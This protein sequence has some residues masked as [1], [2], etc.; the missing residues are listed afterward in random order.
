MNKLDITKIALKN[1]KGFSHFNLEFG[2]IKAIILGG[3]NGFGKT[4]LFDAIELVFTGKIDR[5]VNYADNCHDNR[6]A[7]N[8]NELPLVFDKNQNEVLIELYLSSDD[9]NFILCRRAEVS[10]LTNPISFDPFNELLIKIEGDMEYHPITDDELNR[11]ELKDLFANYKFIN[12]LEQEEATSFLKKKEIE[13]SENINHLFNTITFDNKIENVKKV[14]KLFRDKQALLEQELKHKEKEYE[15]LK[16]THF[17]CQETETVD[18]SPLMNG[19]S[20]P[21]DKE[22]PNLTSEKFNELL[23]EGGIL[24]QIDFFIEHKEEY[25]Q[26][27]TNKQIEGILEPNALNNLSFF[28][29]YADLNSEI[30]LYGQYVNGFKKRF[31]LLDFDTLKDFDLILPGKL[32]LIISDE[33]KQK[34][35]KKI[36]TVTELYESAEKLDKTFNKLFTKRNELAD[37]LQTSN[38]SL[39]LDSCPLCGQQYANSGELIENIAHF[40]DVLQNNISNIK[41]ELPNL[42]FEMR[43]FIQNNVIKIIEDYFNQNEITNEVYIRYSTLAIDELRSTT[44]LLYN[45]FNFVLIHDN[46]V[47]EIAETI[48]DTLSPLLKK[49]DGYISIESLKKTYLS[50]I[51]YFN[52]GK[53]TKGAIKSKRFY[54]INIWNRI[55]SKVLLTVDENCSNIKTKINKCKQ[56]TR[57]L[58]DLKKQLEDKKNNYLNKVIG[59]IEILFYIYSGRIM[60]DNNFGR[61]LFIQNL[62]KKNKDLKLQFVSNTSNQ[63]DVLYRMSSGQL[64][65]V[66]ISYLL[67]INRLYSNKLYLAIDDPIQTIDDIN[68]WGL[69]ETLRHEFSDYFFI[70]STH[71]KSYGSLLR[72]KLSKWG[73]KAKYYDLLEEKKLMNKLVKDE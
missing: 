56:Y 66:V 61:G 34:I 47:E 51:R 73:I 10:K 3:K 60:Q 31:D 2:D 52:D 36:Q 46:T 39:D 71:E 27:V 35:N 25:K 68:M 22:E 11:F 12:Y 42:F 6:V 43:D 26:S 16:H 57:S 8:D 5:Y 20:F 54:L 15:I 65:S 62:S 41:K 13:R 64:V 40:K 17:H 33:V 1:F 4:T 72:Y 7:L 44:D 55:Q 59:D 18:Y 23:Q 30:E 63:V 21:W 19:V 14:E 49:N 45:K 38:N 28:L 53:L 29:Y 69:L 67:A 37:Y 24:D 50:Y 58:K 9:S 48:K 32:N 70:F